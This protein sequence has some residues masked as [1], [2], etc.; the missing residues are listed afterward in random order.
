[1]ARILCRPEPATAWF[2]Y[3]SPTTEEYA[4][5]ELGNRYG[6]TAVHATP[7]R[8]GI[9]LIVGRGRVQPAP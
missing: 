8:P 7:E 6:F 3:Y 1:M 4:S 9:A 5:T 2:N